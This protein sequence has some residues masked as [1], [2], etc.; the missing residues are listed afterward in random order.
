MAKVCSDTSNLNVPIASEIGVEDRDDLEYEE[1][2]D[3]R[4]GFPPVGIFYDDE[5]V[6]DIDKELSSLTQQVQVLEGQNDSLSLE[7]Q[8]LKGEI[9]QLRQQLKEKHKTIR[10]LQEEVKQLQMRVDDLQR[11]QD[12]LY[13]CQIAVEFERALCSHVLP[14][15][16]SRSKGSSSAKLDSLLNMLNGGDMGLIPLDPAKH[17]ITTILGRARQRWEKVCDDLQLRIPP[18]WKATT[19]KEIGNYTH[20]SVPRIFRAMAILKEER[21]P[22]AHP[23]PV[24]LQEAEKKIQTTSMQSV[25]EEW[26]FDLVEEFISS[27]RTSM[28]RSGIQPDQRRFEV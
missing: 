25:L 18:K 15:V 2:M 24:S 10:S 6:E 27:L 26:E 21:N 12:K 13:L 14:E 4:E 8:E 1:S 22:V 11:D 28:G 9:D 16:F 17:N 19:G 20:R 23:N 7:V 3:S 5:K